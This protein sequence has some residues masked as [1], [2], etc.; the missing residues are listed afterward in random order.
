MA[1]QLCLNGTVG[2]SCV[3]G[4]VDMLMKQSSDS[5]RKMV[6]AE[7]SREDTYSNNET[8]T[9]PWTCVDD[10]IVLSTYRI[11]DSV[12]E[13]HFISAKDVREPMR[14]RARG[15]CRQV[16]CCNVD[17]SGRCLGLFGDLIRR[18][19][20]EKLFGLANLYTPR[21]IEI[22]R[23]SSASSSRC[24]ADDAITVPA[25]MSIPVV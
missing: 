22:K 14:D 10:R 21:M 9:S 11:N 13:I 20:V 2:L 24:S 3:S 23:G 4:A 6:S 18:E 16:G 25:K 19:E 17:C 12:E 5:T 8:F 1:H 15:D 7:P